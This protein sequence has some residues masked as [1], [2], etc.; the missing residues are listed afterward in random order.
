MPE[1]NL[2]NSMVLPY[3]GRM[4]LRYT[5]QQEVHWTNLPSIELAYFLQL[6]IPGLGN[7]YLR[8]YGVGGIVFLSFFFIVGWMEVL[9]FPCVL[10]SLWFVG[11]SYRKLPGEKNKPDA[12]ILTGSESDFNW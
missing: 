1:K 5:E 3:L 11:L 10:I 7:V 9:C 12:I 4:A 6:L 8:D 2:I